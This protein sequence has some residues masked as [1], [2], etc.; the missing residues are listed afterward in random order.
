MS[1]LFIVLKVC[2]PWEIFF[3]SVDA[4]FW[5][6]FIFKRLVLTLIS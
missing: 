3:V 5:A 6:Q 1:T 4:L 2:F